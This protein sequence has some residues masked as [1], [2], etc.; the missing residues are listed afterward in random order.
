MDEYMITCLKCGKRLDGKTTNDAQIALMSHFCATKSNE[1]RIDYQSSRK[2]FNMERRIMQLI[3]ELE[4]TKARVGVLELEHGAK[5]DRRAHEALKRKDE[6][7]CR[8]QTQLREARDTERHLR[9][10]VNNLKSAN[11]KL[12]NKGSIYDKIRY[13]YDKYKRDEC[14][15]FVFTDRVEEVLSE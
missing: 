7:I 4:D 14:S 2:Q 5:N 12:Q 9:R 11:E 15:H 1:T 10:H 3:D 8:L 6:I 13:A